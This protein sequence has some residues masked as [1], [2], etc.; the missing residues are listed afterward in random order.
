MSRGLPASTQRWRRRAAPLC[1]N[2]WSLGPDVAR[3]CGLSPEH[4][5]EAGPRLLEKLGVDPLEVTAAER[6]SMA[7]AGLMTAKR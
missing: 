6:L 7:P 1:V 2:R 4:F 3:R 5:D